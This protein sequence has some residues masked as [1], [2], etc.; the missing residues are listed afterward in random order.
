[1][2]LRR[3][4]APGRAGSLSGLAVWLAVL[5][6]LGTAPNPSR[7]ESASF[8]S[9]LKFGVLAHDVRFAGG[10]E[11]GADIN[12]E[13]LFASPIEDRLAARVPKLL[14][15]M[16]QPRPH[17]GFEANTAG[18]TSQIYLGLTWTWQLVRGLVRPDDG[19]D[20]GIGFGPAFNDGKLETHRSD[21]KSLGA[22]ALFHVSFELGY[23]FAPRYEV[24]VYFDHD[25]NAGLARFNQSI[26]DAGL[27]F[28]IHF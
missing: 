21:R 28:G 13:L 12:G 18:D 23:R 16:V 11:S 27:R 9:E 15:W 20:F 22:H 2:Q 26:N 25:S 6:A 3:H 10:K 24:S 8:V 7:A 5:L 1:M 17:I 19:L 4:K 14:R